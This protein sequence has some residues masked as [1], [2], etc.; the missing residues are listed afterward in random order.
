MR[1]L[2]PRQVMVPAVIVFT[3]V[4]LGIRLAERHDR[5]PVEVSPLEPGGTVSVDMVRQ[6][7]GLP[8][9]DCLQLVVFSPDCPFCQHA[10]DREQE[11]LS[12]TSRN[13]RLWYTDKETAT[14][15][16]FVAKHLHR[17]PGISA[18]LVKELKV[19]AV[20]A[21]F[22]LSPKGQI[23]WVGAYYGN[24]SDQELVDRC[25]GQR[26]QGSKT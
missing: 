24:E 10:A 9:D 18:A 20:P 15:P 23:R 12:E 5:I 4:H 26:N 25:T 22:L 2:T 14:L 19:K 1:S 21:L 7:S 3:L 6:A 17:D 8:D 11:S 13:R 16:Y